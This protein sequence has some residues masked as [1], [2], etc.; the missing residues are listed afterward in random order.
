VLDD[1][2]VVY[3]DEVADDVGTSTGPGGLDELFAVWITAQNRIANSTT[4]ATPAA[5][6][7][8]CWSCQLPSSSGLTPEC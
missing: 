6:I 1:E 8:D 3:V 7:T 5:T 4:P 2:L